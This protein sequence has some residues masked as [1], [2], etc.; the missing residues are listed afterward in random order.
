MSTVGSLCPEQPLETLKEGVEQA[1]REARPWIEALGRFGYVAKGV[2]YLIIGTLAVEAAL[3]R[4]GAATDQR[5]A[6]ARVAQAPFGHVMLVVLSVGLLGYAI[7]RFV[8]AGEDTENEGGDLPG[9]LKRALYSL[10][11]VVYLGLALSALRLLVGVGEGSGA[12]QAQDWTAL[13]LSR[14]LGQWLVGL[15]GLAVVANGLVCFY[16]AYSAPFSRKLRVHEMQPEQVDWVTKLGR[17]GYAARGVA[18]CLIGMFIADAALHMDPRRVRGV[19]GALAALAEQ[20]FGPVLMGMVA[21][22]LAAYGA[23][24]LVEARYRRM[25][26]Y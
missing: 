19:D 3:G 20:P 23:F 6:M 17:A 15:V 10:V 12:Q 18:F 14:P 24:A 22:G 26:L 13:L 21:A 1:R 4:G 5:G 16:R 11:G 9:L 7:W 25:Q 2:V 8:Q